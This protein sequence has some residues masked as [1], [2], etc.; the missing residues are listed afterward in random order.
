MKFPIYLDY[1]ATTPVDERVFDAMK[2]YFME[3]FGNAASSG[4]AFGNQAKSAVE[5]S[6]NI[7]ARAINA[8]PEE[9][10]FTSGATESNNLAIKGAD[11][12]LADKGNHIIT[13]VTEHKAVLDTC[14][15]LEKDGVEIT[16]LTVDN[17]GC[18]HLSDLASAINERTILVSLM[19]GNNEI[20]TV[21]DVQKIGAL[22]REKG[23]WFHTD[24]T[25]TIGKIPFDVQ[26]MNV[27]MASLTAH[28]IYG[29]KGVGALYVRNGCK[30]IPQIDGGGHES[31]MRSG[32][33]NV[34][35]IVGFAKSIEVAVAD[36]ERDIAHCTEL[37]NRLWEFL[38]T[39]DGMML[40]GPNPLTQPHKRL[41]NNLSVSISGDNGELIAGSLLNVAVSSRSACTSASNEPSHVLRSIGR[42][43]PQLTTL[44]FGIGRMTTSEEIDYTIDC[45][46]KAIE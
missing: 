15:S 16:Y 41:P 38:K 32:T 19:H 37:R 7:I 39:I 34:P 36:M 29:P 40:N 9:I 25:Q 21:H 10:I 33:L 12:M 3:V 23:V 1:N 11:K 4:H 26:T 22:C 44:R 35:G 14:K 45:I 30:V 46:R 28:K 8:M 5:E 31:G 24:S 43:N 20:G 42:T 6:R 27:D 13:A 17:E 18:V 2:P